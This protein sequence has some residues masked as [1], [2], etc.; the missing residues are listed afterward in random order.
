MMPLQRKEAIMEWLN[1]EK[2]LSIETISLRLGVSEM[3]V[4]RDIKPLVEEGDIV[5]ITGGIAL[6][7]SDPAPHHCAYCLK[8]NYHIHQAQMIYSDQHIEH[9][10]CPHCALMRYHQ[11]TES[12]D[13]I[14]CKDF[15]KGTTISGK[16]AFY[17][18]GADEILGCCAPQVLVFEKKAQAEKFSEGFGGNVV[19][20]QPAVREV[21]K[22]MN[23]SCGCSE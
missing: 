16:N 21:Y 20:L 13:Q 8:S 7:E 23:A 4:Y 10:C 2:T 11:K 19:S 5:R 18:L 9:F 15:L 17:L 22:Q 1:E 6:R 12:V 3:T 14:I